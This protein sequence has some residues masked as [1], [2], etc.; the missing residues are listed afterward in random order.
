MGYDTFVEVDEDYL[1]L[2]LIQ[3][4]YL[5]I[6]QRLSVYKFDEGARLIWESNL[7][8]FQ[9]MGVNEVDEGDL[10]LVYWD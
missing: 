9:E 10:F 1:P 4:S 2:R 8:I 7:Q 5:P 3:E 6:L